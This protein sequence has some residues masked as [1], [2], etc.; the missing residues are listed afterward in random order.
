MNDGETEERLPAGEFAFSWT[1]LKIRG[2]ILRIIKR[3]RESL[4][5]ST[6]VWI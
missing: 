6:C 2:K 3:F 4:I 1:K 5:E